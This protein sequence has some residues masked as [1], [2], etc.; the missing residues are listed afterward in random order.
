MGVPFDPK[1]PPTTQFSLDPSVYD[2]QSLTD[3][4]S[5]ANFMGGISD[6]P[7]SYWGT[8]VPSTQGYPTSQPDSGWSDDII[9]GV[10]D[11]INTATNWLSSFSSAISAGISAGTEQAG[12]SIGNGVFSVPSTFGSGINNAVSQHVGQTG[13][14]L[15]YGVVA[16]AALYLVIKVI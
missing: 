6:S 16:I 15:L 3:Q 1:S 11:S 7:Q 10:G 9:G 5:I 4:Q 13:A 2:Y 8:A 14:Y 12:E